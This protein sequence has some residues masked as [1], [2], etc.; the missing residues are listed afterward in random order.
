MVLLSCFCRNSSCDFADNM[1]KMIYLSLYIPI[2][3]LIKSLLRPIPTADT[4]PHLRTPW[5]QQ[6]P[7]L[8][9]RPPPAG[10]GRWAAPAPA[11]LPGTAATAV[12]CRGPARAAPA[13]CPAPARSAGAAAARWEEAAA[14]A[15]PGSA[16]RGA[17]CSRGRGGER[18]RR[19][20]RGR[21]LTV[22]LP[23]LGGGLR[24]AGERRRGSPQPALGPSPR[25]ALPGKRGSLPC[26]TAGV[27]R[28]LPPPPSPPPPVNGREPPLPLLPVCGGAGRPPAVPS[29][30]AAVP[31]LRGFGQLRPGR[32]RAPG[33][34]LAAGRGRAGPLGR[35]A[36]ERR[37]RGASG[38]PGAGGRLRR[39]GS[40]WFLGAAS[41]PALKSPR[42]CPGVGRRE[43]RST[44]LSPGP[45]GGP[46]GG[47]P[48]PLACLSWAPRPDTRCGR[49]VRHR[50]CSPGVP[51][52]LRRRG[53]PR[54]KN[55]WN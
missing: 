8:G 14:V 41:P 15:A 20:G 54:T 37:A 16:A 7:A 24:A 23:R 30:S 46:G 25:R 12:T 29:G 38:C 21:G 44:E 40:R 33:R 34:P 35:G 19:E 31:P 43:S 51:P 17:A 4:T 36:R 47:C 1:W 39:R 42:C 9:I 5:Q 13:R 10:T 6:Q 55:S 11:P 22:G 48:V 26:G 32:R 18:R 28:A 27:R 2:R 52:S 53:E 49:K 3:Q 45:P 50:D